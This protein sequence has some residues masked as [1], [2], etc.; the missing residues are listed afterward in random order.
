MG[1]SLRGRMV[2][3][4]IEMDNVLYSLRVEVNKS[5]TQTELTL[6]MK[7]C[8]H[9]C[10]SKVYYN[11]ESLVSNKFLD[12]ESTSIILASYGLSLGGV[13]ANNNAILTTL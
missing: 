6:L 5:N 4:G 1:L 8:N 13:I 11:K 12:K 10:N 3:A 9:I 7:N 2:E